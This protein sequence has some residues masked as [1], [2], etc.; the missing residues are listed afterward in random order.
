[1]KQIHI[2]GCSPRSGT[3]LLHEMM[4]SC[5]QHDHHCDHEI[6]IMKCDGDVLTKAGISITKDPNEVLIAGRAMTFNPDLHILYLRRDPRDV[7][8]SSHKQAPDKYFTH[9]GTWKRYENAARKLTGHSRFTI[10]SYEE[11]V[12]KPDEVQEKIEKQF[13][14][15]KKIA[16]FSKFNEVANPSD[17]S[18]AALNGLR[19]VSATSIGRWTQHLQRVANQIALHGDITPWLIEHGYET[20]P[21]WQQH[22]PAGQALEDSFF[23]DKPSLARRFKQWRRR[24]RKLRDYRKRI[25]QITAKC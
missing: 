24:N 9:L 3:T 11:L 25:K 13:S 15:L 4:I 20:D 18:A 6:S 12:M 17:H 5:F 22:L 1:M 2:V 23:E 7:I 10:I 21:Q 16:P 19:P 8:V 14:W